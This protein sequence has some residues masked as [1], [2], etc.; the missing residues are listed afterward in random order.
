M[1]QSGSVRSS[2]RRAPHLKQRR[3]ALGRFIKSR[4]EHL[5]IELRDAA[6]RVGTSRWTY[7]EWESGERSIQT[8]LLPVLATVLEVSVRALAETVVVS[9]GK[10]K[11][12][13][14]QA[15]AA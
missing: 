9:S 4:R 2:W 6:A 14:K 12:R 10:R 7:T 5:K 15:A 13:A 8:E 1:Q 3:Q 11:L